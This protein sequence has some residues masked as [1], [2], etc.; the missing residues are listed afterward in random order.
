MNPGS[1]SN[2]AK[3]AVKSMLEH[4][5]GLS[6][7]DAQDAAMN[8]LARVLFVHVAATGGSLSDIE[9]LAEAAKDDLVEAVTANWN[10]H[11]IAHV[12]R[13]HDA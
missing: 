10:A 6:A 2:A 3:G 11:Q 7:E 5:D 4:L 8:V 9:T 12:R 13:G 1:A